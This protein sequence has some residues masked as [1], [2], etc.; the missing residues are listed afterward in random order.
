MWLN[1]VIN[2]LKSVI[3]S[4]IGVLWRKHEQNE[5]SDAQN[6]VDVASDDSVADQLRE[7]WTRK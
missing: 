5:V 3:V 4:V 7:R 1:L 6:K 2:V